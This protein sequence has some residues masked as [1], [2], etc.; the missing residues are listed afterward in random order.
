MTDPYKILGVSPSASEEEIKKAYKALAKKYHPD[1]NIGAPNI[2]EIQAKFVEV[3]QAYNLIMDIK[4]GK[5]SYNPHGQSNGNPHGQSGYG[6]PYGQS[7]YGSYQNGGYSYTYTYGPFG[8]YEGSY[9][10]YNLH[11]NPDNTDDLPMQEAVRLI[12]S[13]RFQ[14]ALQTLMHSSS[15]SARWHYLCALAYTGMGNMS[16]A[17]EMAKAAVDAEPSNQTYC[18]FSESLYRSSARYT[19][20]GRTYTRPSILNNFCVRLILFNALLNL[21]GCFCNSCCCCKR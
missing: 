13:R 6:N 2:D 5:A 15:R 7:S 4:Q 10:N 9:N 1:M 20:T 14:E 12:N 21:L 16:K 11:A 8:F 18:E 3:Q 19:S 17:R